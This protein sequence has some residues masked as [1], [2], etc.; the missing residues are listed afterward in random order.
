MERL[1]YGKDKRENIV[2]IEPNDFDGTLKLYYKDGT[3]EKIPQTFWCLSN[4][5]HDANYTR[6]ATKG[7]DKYRQR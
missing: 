3:I 4:T 5:K 7:S 6:L 2:S 1:I